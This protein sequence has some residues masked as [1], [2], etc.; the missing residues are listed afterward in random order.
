MSHSSAKNHIINIQYPNTKTWDTAANQVKFT[1]QNVHYSLANG[2]RRAMIA[3]VPTIGFKSE[4][5]KYSTIKI[6]RNDTYYLNNQII[7]HRLAMIPINIPNPDTFDTEDYVFQLDVTNDTNGML[8]VTTEHI[9]VK[10][11][12]SNSY[13]SEKE[14]RAMFPVDPN[15]GH[16]IPIAKLEPKYYADV[17]HSPE[18][19]ASLAATLKLPVSEPITLRLS[20]KAVKGNGNDNGHFSPVTACAYGNTVDDEKAKSGLVDFIT[21]QNEY[22]AK[23]SL[24]AYPEDTLIRRFN[25]NEV[26][27]HYKTDEYGDPSSFDFT[28]ESVGVIPPLI[29]LERGFRWLIEAVQQLIGNLESGNEKIITVTPIATMGNGFSILVEGE[30]DTLGNLIQ[31][32][33]VRQYADYSL[34]V[35]ERRLE[36]CTYHKTHPLERRIMFTVK[37]L[38]ASS[39]EE[40]ISTVFIPGLKDIMKNITN[41]VNELINMPEYLAEA[42]R[43]S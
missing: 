19:A 23:N 29:C 35:T 11:I 2:V 24:T 39:P 41:I 36:S 8:L 26:Q 6:E 42:K 15:T 17:H 3:K 33:M 5:D 22:T 13:L 32:H 12:S 10:R 31:S 43:I 9:K 28:V 37:P 40:C 18:V 38:D 34:P 21:A 30:D 1:L 25:I 16:F 27:R 20:A 7:S 4:P 14:T